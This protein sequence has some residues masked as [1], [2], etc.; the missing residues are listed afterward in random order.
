MTEETNG[1]HLGPGARVVAH[2]RIKGRYAVAVVL[3]EGPFT[4]DDALAKVDE[5]R[6]RVGGWVSKARA[7]EMLGISQKQVDKLRID[8]DLTWERDCTDRVMIDVNSVKEFKALR[9]AGN[10]E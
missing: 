6:E 3:D 5:Y 9:D 7:A 8:G 4:K 2:R 10:A 1:Y